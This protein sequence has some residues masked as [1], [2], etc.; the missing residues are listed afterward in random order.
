MAVPTVTGISPAV[1]STRGRVVV[2]IQGTNFRLPDAPPLAGYVGGSYPL[3][4]EVEIGGQ[5]CAEAQAAT[6]ELIYA[7]VPEWRGDVDDLPEALDVTVRN[8]DASGV[9]IPSEEATLADAY[10]VKHPEYPVECYLQRT[11]RALLDLFKRHVL[12]NVRITV[13]RDYVEDPSQLE[14]LQASLPVVHLIGPQTPQNRFYSVNREPAEEDPS[15]AD[16][17][18]RKAVPVTEDVAFEVQ[19][20]ARTQR[21]IYGIGMA[22]TLLFRDVVSLRVDNIAGDPSKGYKEY[23]V[24]IPFYGHPT[25]NTAANKDGLTSLRA[26]VEIKGVHLDDEAGTIVER[27]WRITTNDGE[28]TVNVQATSP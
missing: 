22:I 19:A 17:F 9:P 11:V 14:R 24:G 5:V 28:P 10:T 8:V 23:E 21:E 6:A 25:Y 26:Q 16:A 18:L 13:K 27:G 2:A 20:W 7:A 3:S 12:G 4:V 1:G 15:D